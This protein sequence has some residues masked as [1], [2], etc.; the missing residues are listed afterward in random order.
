MPILARE[1]RK[2][3]TARVSNEVRDTLKRAAEL[4]GS[5][6]NQFVMQTAYQ[7]AQRILERETIIRLSQ[8]NA[9]RVFS[10]LEHPPK[11]NRRLKESVKA[12]KESVRV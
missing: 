3:V 4:V 9:R 5:T 12:F 2:R 7:E 1:Q 8:E 6:V 10:L 11:P